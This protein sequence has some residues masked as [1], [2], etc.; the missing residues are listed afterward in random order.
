MPADPVSY[1]PRGAGGKEEACCV[2]NVLDFRRSHALDRVRPPLTPSTYPTR[3]ERIVV[4]KHEGWRSTYGGWICSVNNRVYP[5]DISL[6]FLPATITHV[7]TRGEMREAGTMAWQVTAQSVQKHNGSSEK[8][9]LT[10][11]IDESTFLP[12]HQDRVT[13]YVQPGRASFTGRFRAAYTRFGEPMQI[14]LPKS[15]RPT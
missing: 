11:S 3:H 2:P 10:F 1:L 8:T 6:L 9:R 7:V 15:C 14:T 4:G 13:I 12:I 5:A